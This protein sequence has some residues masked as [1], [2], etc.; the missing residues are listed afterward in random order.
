MDI[1]DIKT[2]ITQ[3]FIDKKEVK[4]VYLFGSHAGNKATRLSDIDIALY[5]DE[6]LNSN[7][8][9]EFRLKLIS[10]V[11]TVIKTDKIDLIILNDS[12]LL[13]SFNVVHDGIIICAN[14]EKKRIQFETK[15][16]SF[17]FDQQYYFKRHAQA[18]INRIAK[19]GI[20]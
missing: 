19:E 11:S 9:F 3:Y 15:I 5:L 4:F 16:M 2:K 20:L 7:E 17:Y 12:P 1:K 14:D 13:L 18:T 6:K 8:R 10:E